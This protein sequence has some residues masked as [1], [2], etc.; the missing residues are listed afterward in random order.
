MSLASQ[1]PPEDN[2]NLMND[3]S[4]SQFDQSLDAGPTGSVDDIITPMSAQLSYRGRPVSQP[5]QRVFK[6]EDTNLLEYATTSPEKDLMAVVGVHTQD[7][8][9]ESPLQPASPGGLTWKSLGKSQ[10]NITQPV[11]DN[12]RRRPDVKRNEQTTRARDHEMMKTQSLASLRTKPLPKV[13]P[14]DPYDDPTGNLRNNAM[15]PKRIDTF[16]T[17]ESKHAK[18]T[19][20][21]QLKKLRKYKYGV[22]P[23]QRLKLMDKQLKQQVTPL[24]M[25]DPNYSSSIAHVHSNDSITEP[26]GAIDINLDIN[27][28]SPNGLE[29]PFPGISLGDEKSV[30]ST[31]SIEQA[32]AIVSPV[33]S[34]KKKEIVV[35][36]VPEEKLGYYKRV[37]V[38]VNFPAEAA[39]PSTAASTA[40]STANNSVAGASRGAASADTSAQLVSRLMSDIEESA[41][42]AELRG[43]SRPLTN[44]PLQRYRCVFCFSISNH[45][46]TLF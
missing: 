35:K 20:M 17:E 33:L 1:F 24:G 19:Y 5:A 21:K 29:V 22:P 31:H 36:N 28:P 46:V 23:D 3:E 15:F 8:A 34:T 43:Q 26:T 6:L 37:G 41:I 2:D 18:S 40:P 27:P 16:P 25:L 10:K 32:A 12:T 13:V 9:H 11:V 39:A 7:S 45:F 14:E 42:E 44:N 30:H 4:V 38:G